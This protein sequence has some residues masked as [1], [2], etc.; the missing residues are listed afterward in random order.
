MIV[1][2]QFP[3]IF[4][5]FKALFK[6]LH[7]PMKTETSCPFKNNIMR[8]T[9]CGISI[10]D[11]IQFSS[12]QSLSWV[13]LYLT[14]W[15]TA[16]QATLSIT[17]S[18]SLPKLMSI[19]SVMPSNHFILCHPFSSR[20]ES[21]PASGSFPM[22]QFFSSGGQNIGVS[23]STSLLPMNTQGW[24]PLGWTGWIL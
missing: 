6:A 10:Q 12:V 18:Q 15:T 13:W 24:S 7:K 21:F 23:A 1:S 4:L 3:S 20:L 16:L 11:N 14:P 22:S 8:S 2:T 9:K 19:E 17:N 5:I